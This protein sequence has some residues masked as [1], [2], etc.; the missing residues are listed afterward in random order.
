[1][2]CLANL[3]ISLVV[4]HNADT[5]GSSK[6]LHYHGIGGMGVGMGGMAVG[7]GGTLPRE[8]TQLPPASGNWHHPAGPSG[9]HRIPH[10]YLKMA[11][12][13]RP[14]WCLANSVN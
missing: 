7:V 6:H 13:V 1:M 5:N 4:H 2:R 14:I 9:Y 3:S 8:H 12:K 10:K 11:T